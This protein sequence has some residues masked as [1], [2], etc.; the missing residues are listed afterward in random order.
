MSITAYNIR[1][2]LCHLIVIIGTLW[3]TLPVIRTRKKKAWKIVFAALTAVILIAVLFSL[4]GSLSDRDRVSATGKIIDI[5]HN[6]SLFGA[7]DTYDIR[8]E[9]PDGTTKWYHT[10]IFSSSSFKKSVAKLNIGDT[11]ELYTN[12]FFDIFYRYHCS[13]GT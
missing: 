3:L 6:G 1:I 10:S 11:V 9:H 5:T 7:L 8:V 4:F 13:P 2:I 12:N